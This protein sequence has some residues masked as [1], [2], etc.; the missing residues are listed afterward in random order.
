MKIQIIKKAN[1]QIQGKS[2]PFF[3]DAPPTGVDVRNGAKA[4]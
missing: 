1:V 2:C 3:V 4:K